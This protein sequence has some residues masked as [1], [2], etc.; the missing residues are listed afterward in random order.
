MS[1]VFASLIV[2]LFVTLVG[3]AQTPAQPQAPTQIQSLSTCNLTP[4][5]SL[6]I[7][8]IKLGMSAEQI[9]S[10]FPSPGQR[11]TVFQNT[12]G[13]Y[14]KYGAVESVISPRDYP[15]IA[16]DKFA[17]VARVAVTLFNGR[18]TEFSVDYAG[19]PDGPW[20]SDVDCFFAKLSGPFGLPPAKNWLG[21]RFSKTLNCNGLEIEARLS[22][23]NRGLILLRSNTDI[24]AMKERVAAEEEKKRS[25]LKP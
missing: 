25:E 12:T 20:W 1:R 2:I 4:S 16:N 23:G 5:Q 14:P 15:S 17:D 8:G 22:N 6:A 3:S 21:R 19:P 13:R 18:L 9:N 24:D 11:E 7:R 10:V